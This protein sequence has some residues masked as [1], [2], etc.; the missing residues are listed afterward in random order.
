[1]IRIIQLCPPGPTN[2]PLAP[3]IAHGRTFYD[4][5]VSLLTQMSCGLETH[6]E[7]ITWRMNRA[8]IKGIKVFYAQHCNQ[9][10]LTAQDSG[11]LVRTVPNAAGRSLFLDVLLPVCQGR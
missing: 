6:S 4:T 9:G 11:R 8:V 1:M 5:L 7:L 10:D 3:V 2:H